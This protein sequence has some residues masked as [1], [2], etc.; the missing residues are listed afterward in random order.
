MEPGRQVAGHDRDTDMYMGFRDPVN[1]AATDQGAKGWGGDNITFSPDG[2][3]LA[4][5]VSTVNLWKVAGW[6]LQ[7][8]LIAPPVRPNKIRNIGVKSLHFSPDGKMLVVAYTMGNESV[9]A[10]RVADGGIAWTYEPQ[11]IMVTTPLVFTPDGKRI[12]LGIKEYGG[13]DVDFRDTYRILLL[14]AASGELLR[15]IDE[16][17]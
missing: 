7:T 2:K 4:S 13:K 16:S 17:M 11:R 3:Y 10:Y 8:T 1:P 6:S 14:D 12:I 15:S 9:I 5:G